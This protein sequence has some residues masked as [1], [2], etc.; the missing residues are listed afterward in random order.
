MR[1]WLTKQDIKDLDNGKKVYDEYA[2]YFYKEDD[3]KYGYMFPLDSSGVETW[4]WD[5]EYYTKDELFELLIEE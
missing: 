1:P 3:N 2:N 5:V 4:D